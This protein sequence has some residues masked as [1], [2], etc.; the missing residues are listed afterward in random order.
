MAE[1]PETLHRQLERGVLPR[2]CFIAGE[3]PLLQREAADA[4]RRAARETGH[5]E[6][7]V[8]DV[9][10]GFDWGRLTEAAGSLSLF[11]D[12]RLLEVRMP[13]GKPGRD[14]AEALKSYCRDAPEDT[15][16]LV[17]SGRLERSAREAAWARALAGAGIFVYCWPVPGRDMPRWV[18][19]RLR[20]AGLQADPEAAALIAERSEGN[21]LAADQ[22][23]EKLRLLVGSGGG[24]DVETAAGALADSARYTVDDLA[25]AA[26]D[27]EWTRALRV[28]AALEEEGVQPPLIL[29]ALARD[30]RVAARLAAGAD[31]GVLQRERIWKR[32]A[33]RLRNAARR[34]PVAT[35]RQLLQR[36][37]RVDRAIKGLPPGEPWEQLRALVSRLARAMA[38]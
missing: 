36:C 24:V 4:V 2:V 6:R 11:G 19:E 26:L 15:V 7:E 23:V 28:L 3:E 8:L 32:R 33:A 22:A 9:D 38:K 21:L 37:H 27:G 5:A 13:G 35:W 16:L 14:G 10:A 30:I 1:R 12:R 17:T 34:R 18:A 25:D 20:R 31:E 29:W